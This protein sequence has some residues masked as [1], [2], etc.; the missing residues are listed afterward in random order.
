MIQWSTTCRL[1]SHRR[2]W[3]RGNVPAEPG[4]MSCQWP[5][6]DSRATPIVCVPAAWPKAETSRTIVRSSLGLSAVRPGSIPPTQS[7]MFRPSGS[8][9]QITMHLNRAGYSP[10]LRTVTDRRSLPP[11]AASGP[12]GSRSRPLVT[13]RSR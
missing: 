12:E 7:S 5:R 10:M 1:G 8:R 3:R 2:S 13:T 4:G 11:T 6:F 9:A